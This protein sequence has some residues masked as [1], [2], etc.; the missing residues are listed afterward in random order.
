MWFERADGR[1]RQRLPGARMVHVDG[2]EAARKSA[3]NRT[4]GRVLGVCV[5]TQPARFA[6]PL[7][8]VRSYAG[9]GECLGFVL[10]PSQRDSRRPCRM[11][12]V[13]THTE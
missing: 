3:R 8:C 12:C 10:V 6:P 13:H 9:Q 5:G 2:R 11:L 7:R 4:S 1:W